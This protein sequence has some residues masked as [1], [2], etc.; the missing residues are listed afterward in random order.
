MPGGRELLAALDPLL[1][2]A[3]DLDADQREI[4]LAAM[5]LE[6]PALAQELE[7]LLAQ[8][9][10]LEARGFLGSDE[11][12]VVVDVPSLA[13]VNIGAYTLE[14]PIGRGGMGS[15]WLGR[16]S[17]GRF[18]GTAAVKLLNLA[19]LD[20]VGAER[21]AREGTL[22][23]QLAHPNIARLLDAGVTEA[24]QPFLVLEYVQGT[25]IDRYC[26]V[27]G[28]GPTQRLT[29]FRQVLDAVEHAHANLIVH[30]DLKP[31]NILV[32]SEG[33]A[34]LLDFG[35]AKL[36][37]GE[38]AGERTE[39]T[40]R[41]GLTFTPEYAAPEQVLGGPI[42][43]GTDVYSL[44]VLI[45][46]L[47]T[48]RH[49]TSGG[50]LTTA[51]HLS[52][53]LDTEPLRLST[54]VQESRLQRAYRGDLDNILAKALKKDPTQRYPTVT[55]LADDLDRH[56][57]HEP[58]S[59]R[60]DSLGYRARKFVRRNRTGVVAAALVFATLAAAAVVTTRQMVEAQKQRSEAEQQR[61]VAQIQRD[62]ARYEQRR[63]EASSGFMNFL[64]QDIAPSG[65][66]FTTLE[67]LDRGRQLLETEYRDEPRFLAR[68][69]AQLADHYYAMSDRV[70]EM[71][72]LK[73]A[74]EIATVADDP[75]AV[76]YANCS[77]G[78]S[79][80]ADGALDSAISHLEKA[81]RYLERVR[82]PPL[83]VRIHCLR[84]RS[85]WGRVAG[86]VDSALTWAGTAVALSEAAGDTSS[87]AYHANLNEYL[88]VLQRTGRLGDALEVVRQSIGVL[89][90]IGRL[91]TLSG[92]T[93][94]YNEA[95]LLSLLGEKRAAR[96]RVQRVIERAA[97]MQPDARAPVHMRLMAGDLDVI[98]RRGDS[99]V[100]V[101]RSALAQARETGDRPS[102]VW[103]LSSLSNALITQGRF[104]E[105]QKY[106]K[107]LAAVP[108]NSAPWNLGILE[109]RLATMRGNLSEAH[110]KLQEHFIARGYPDQRVRWPHFPERLIEASSIALRA[111]EVESAE[112][113][114]RNALIQAGEEGQDSTRSGVIGDGQVMLTRILLARGDSAAAWNALQQA[115]PALVN[116]YGPNHPRTTEARALLDSLIRVI[117]RVAD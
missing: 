83:D 34:K 110:R 55:A 33:E 112:S 98:L 99:A 16:R 32:T 65:K 80:A 97:G 67:L 23:A 61:D 15:V 93:E 71:A 115:Q 49:P 107:E 85:T 106:M 105:A 68:M 90:R 29:L 14:T 96:D 63:A 72:V 2:H 56:L 78:Q 9:S 18:Q 101:F 59:A 7:A 86:K 88:I 64:L 8:E 3:L 36:V 40:A 50:S 17:D 22:L 42:T 37:A 54:V 43:T 30:R 114:A 108:L 41:G 24:G 70:R 60:P 58:V 35:I 46:L 91:N 87:E 13:G 12:A 5:R 53:I 73:R 26:E 27:H 100:A 11:Q 6:R 89:D 10:R 21:F 39:L 84:A 47:L 57:R 111:G 31:S 102:Q 48:G 116:A 95:I 44:G 38:S 109:A 20:R 66:P 25:R 51:G 1:D 19:L 75:E 94:Q 62:R 79:E 82:E 28:L 74:D 69:M 52:G 81:M 104:S 92:V 77:L 76:A 45:Y 103:A 117:Q 113:L 4:W